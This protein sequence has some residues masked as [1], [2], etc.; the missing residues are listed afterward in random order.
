MAPRNCSIPTLQAECWKTAE[1]HGFHDD[2]PLGIALMLIV[3]ELAEALEDQRAGHAPDETWYENGKPCG[4]P[5]EL[6]DAV[7]RI[8]DTAEDYKVNLEDIILEKMAYNKTR[9]YKHGKTM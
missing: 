1:D 3:S 9:P 7:I 2:R 8:F 5:S 6:A 4:I